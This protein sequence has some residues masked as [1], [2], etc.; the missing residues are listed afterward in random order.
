MVHENLDFKLNYC[1][2]FQILYVNHLN[3]FSVNNI[4]KYFYD[5]LKSTWGGGSR[6]SISSL[7]SVTVLSLLTISEN[8]EFRKNI[9]VRHLN[10]L[11][12][13]HIA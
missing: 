8:L 7:L 3:M 10:K 9:S 2:F 6:I 11:I 4:C 13:I 12:I 1:N 5:V